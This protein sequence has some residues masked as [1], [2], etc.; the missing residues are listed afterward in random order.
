MLKRLQC[1]AC[2]EDLKKKLG[3]K[4]QAGVRIY[5]NKS[6]ELVRISPEHDASKGDMDN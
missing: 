1:W 5:E 2:N 3:I 4:Y 6:T